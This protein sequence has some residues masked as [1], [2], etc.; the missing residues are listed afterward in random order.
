M[1]FGQETLA[2]LVWNRPVLFMKFYRSWK[3]SRVVEH[4]EIR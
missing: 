3:P 2:Q 4:L 1:Y